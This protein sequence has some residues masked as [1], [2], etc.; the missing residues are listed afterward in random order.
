MRETGFCFIVKDD[1]AGGYL[2]LKENHQPLKVDNPNILSL[3]H[4]C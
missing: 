2:I 4:A 3:M 1:D